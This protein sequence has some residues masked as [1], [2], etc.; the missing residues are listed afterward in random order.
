[1]R[2]EREREIQYRNG[3]DPRVKNWRT[4]LN[5]ADPFSWRHRGASSGIPARENQRIKTTPGASEEASSLR[6]STMPSAKFEREPW[7]GLVSD[8]GL[9]FVSVDFVNSVFAFE[10]FP[11]LSRPESEIW[12]WWRGYGAYRLSGQRTVATHRGREGGWVGFLLIDW[13]VGRFVRFEGQLHSDI[14][15]CWMHYL[16]ISCLRK[17]ILNLISEKFLV[18]QGFIKVGW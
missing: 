17:I 12:K 2:S 18:F 1:M 9:V 3:R 6:S 4:T 5:L 13:S 7:T 11:R 8:I 15:A 16:K 10:E 14:R